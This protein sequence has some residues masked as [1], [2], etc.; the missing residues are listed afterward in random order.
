MGTVHSDKVDYNAQW[1]EEQCNLHSK[2]SRDAS[3]THVGTR[4]PAMLEARR[5]QKQRKPNGSQGT[6]D[7]DEESMDQSFTP[8]FSTLDGSMQLG[9]NGMLAMPYGAMPLMPAPVMSSGLSAMPVMPQLAGEG[10]SFAYP[11]MP[12]PSFTNL[13]MQIPMHE[14]PP[15]PAQMPQNPQPIQRNVVGHHQRNSSLDGSVQTT[16]HMTW[17]PPTSHPR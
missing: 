2:I 14:L 9:P 13:S 5:L 1:L 4:D 16:N 8:D 15:M 10:G 6:P 12:A 3:K 7:F 17:S 11:P